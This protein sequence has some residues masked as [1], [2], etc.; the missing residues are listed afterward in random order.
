MTDIEQ[1]AGTGPEVW[2]VGRPPLSGTPHLR[3]TS[4][5]DKGTGVTWTIGV[6][7]DPGGALIVSAPH[8]RAGREGV[9]V[10]CVERALEAL[11]DD[12]HQGPVE[13]SVRAKGF[14]PEEV[15]TPRGVS[16]V[17]LEGEEMSPLPAGSVDE[18]LFSLISDETEVVR[19]ARLTLWHKRSCESPH[20]IFKPINDHICRTNEVRGF[21]EPPISRPP[22]TSIIGLAGVGKSS[23]ISALLGLSGEDLPPA[24]TSRTTLCPIAFRNAPD[25]R[26]FLLTVTLRSEREL[27]R[28][29]SDRLTAGIEAALRAAR[30]PAEAFRPGS[31]EAEALMRSPDALFD[32]RFTLGR[33]SEEAAAW[34]ELIGQ[35]RELLAFSIENRV[36]GDEIFQYGLTEPIARTIW[37]RVRSAIG[38]LPFGALIETDSG[39]LVFRY[40]TPLRK[41]AIE[42]GRRFYAVGLR[43][44]G[45]SFGPFCQRVT[46]SGPWVSARPF[47]LVDN[48]GFDHEGGL[49]RVA[50][51]DL[52]DEIAAADRVLIV[53]SAEKVGDRQT[54]SLI[55]RI[56]ADGEGGKVLFA[57]TRA[58]IPLRR[59]ADL[60]GHVKA[61][62]LN[63]LNALDEAVGPNAVQVVRDNLRKHP[64]FIFGNLDRAYENGAAGLLIAPVD[65]EIDLDNASEAGRLLRLLCADPDAA[66]EEAADLSLEFSE[67]KL[68]AALS[69]AWGDAF[70][71]CLVSYGPDETTRGTLHWGTVKSEVRNVTRNAL[72]PEGEVQIGDMLLLGEYARSVSAALSRALDAPL[73]PDGSVAEA[74]ERISRGANLLR[75]GLRPVIE[76]GVISRIIEAHLETWVAARDLS[77][78]TFGPGSTLERASLIRLILRR[79][80]ERGAAIIFER[81]VI[82]GLIAGGAN[83]R[84]ASR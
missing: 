79:S 58:D 83:I 57:C 47:E 26:L 65:E 30:A 19:G 82:A 9:I 35:M 32:L 15:R 4:R 53:E 17:P 66:D 21:Q 16:L 36:S 18:I 60:D 62:L 72:E 14:L 52:V 73:T 33:Y 24:S 23:L 37:G 20:M 80:E 46:L 56:I 28:R 43:Y 5:K 50:G 40:A 48:R 69:A 84:R 64:P 70:A 81:S 45:K 1:D 75:R 59:G 7:M 71:A 63:G 34:A 13:M 11:R 39:E 74:A 10:A 61:G 77:M 31:S 49:D 54:M 3:F 42:A 27:I 44:A 78:V 51:D 41:A 55:S 8:K 25:S 38:S 29:V 12:G 76:R 6:V 2:R 67:K 22:V 68:R